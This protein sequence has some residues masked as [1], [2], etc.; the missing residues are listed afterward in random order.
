MGTGTSVKTTLNEKLL[1]L[2]FSWLY[3]L[4]FLDL[5]A[6]SLIV[7][8]LST[9]LR[10][11]GTSHVLTGV[12]C[13]VYPGVQ[14]F[15]GPIVGCWS[16]KYGRKRMLLLSLFM[17]AFC[18]YLLGLSTSVITLFTLR[19]IIGIFKHTQ[20]LCK[21][22]VINIIP[23]VNQSQAY[24]ILNATTAMGYTLGPLIAGHIIELEHGFLYLTLITCLVFIFNIVL[25]YCLLPDDSD[26]ANNNSNTNSRIDQKN[27]RNDFKNN[28]SNIVKMFN[29]LVKINWL[30]YWDI[31]LLKFLLFLSMSIFY[32]NYPL[33]IEEEFKVSIK[34]I[35]YASSFQGLISSVCGLFID[36][37]W[38]SYVLNKSD[39]CKLFY[40]FFVLSVSFLCVGFV[41]NFVTFVVS[42]I[43]LCYSSSLLRIITTKTLL[44]KSSLQ[45]HRGSLIGAENT[46][47]SVAHLIGPLVSGFCRDVV[48]GRLH[49]SLLLP[50]I[51][52]GAGATLSA[53]L[54][55]LVSLKKYR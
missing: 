3:L 4:S 20:T 54:H 55:Y 14:L 23:D 49:I 52:A 16:D 27:N 30:Y 32:I 48:F 53:S 26:D 15:S 21:A 10:A 9:R 6:T 34:F 25:V 51:L 31:F 41:P 1:L 2:H 5:F 50:A 36:Q 29:E 43:P 33:M 11:L 8:L 7:P 37:L 28:N 19:F 13:A 18:Y 45:Q 46:V 40:C 35:G 39:Y 12:I 17:C 24:G 47:A 38:P 22:L 42:L 44:E